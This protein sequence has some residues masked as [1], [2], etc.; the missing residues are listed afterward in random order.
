MTRVPTTATYRLYMSQITKQKS[1]LSDVSYQATTGNRYS[2]YDKYGLST[3]RLLSLQNERAVTTK[4]L[5]TNS[6]TKVVLESQQKAVDGIR[7]S[8]TSGRKC[9]IS[10]PAI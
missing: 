6:I 5:E 2:S 3:Y 10:I 7:A 1:A 9:A 8:L 4:Y